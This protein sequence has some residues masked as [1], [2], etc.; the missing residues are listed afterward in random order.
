MI[1]TTIRQLLLSNV[2]F[3]ILLDNSE[4]DRSLPIFIGAAEAQAI[5]FQLNKVELPRPLTHDLF[6]NTLD[7]L[8]YDVARVEIYDLHEGTFFANIILKNDDGEIMIDARPSDAI[9]IAIRSDSPIFVDEQIMDTAGRI[10]NDDD[11]NMPQQNNQQKKNTERKKIYHISP[12][13]KLKRSLEKAIEDE[14]YEDAGKLRDEINKLKD[15]H[16]GN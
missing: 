1:L 16:T 4:D 8:D 6:V 3:I 14:R 11:E 5:A 7:A 2:G 15:S 10:F 9:A 13:K 12:I